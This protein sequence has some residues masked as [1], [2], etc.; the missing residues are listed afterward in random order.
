MLK[1]GQ[2]TAVSAKQYTDA[3]HE[4]HDFLFAH[5]LP[6][7]YFMLSFLQ[8]ILSYSARSGAK[9]FFETTASSSC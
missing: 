6:L 2:L 7:V 4:L 1:T 8:M 3:I 5:G 9:S